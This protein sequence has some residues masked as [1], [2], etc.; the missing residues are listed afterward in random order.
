MIFCVSTVY[1]CVCLCFSPVKKTQV[2][3]VRNNIFA[4]GNDFNLP[5]SLRIRRVKAKGR[6][7]TVEVLNRDSSWEH[8]NCECDAQNQG[9]CFNC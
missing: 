1:F 4:V 5:C 8:L 6:I 9:I 3:T 2:G 7:T